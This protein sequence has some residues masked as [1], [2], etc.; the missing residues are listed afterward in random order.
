M[1]GDLEKILAKKMWQLPIFEIKMG[2]DPKTAMT[3]RV[4]QTSAIKGVEHTI[5]NIVRHVVDGEKWYLIFALPEGSQDEYRLIKS[6][7]GVAYL[8][9]EQPNK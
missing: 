2:I 7:D 3:F 4:G 1:S 9:F 6:W 5:T 8:T